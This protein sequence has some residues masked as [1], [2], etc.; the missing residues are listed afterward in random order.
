MCVRLARNLFKTS[1]F[2]PCRRV[3]LAVSGGSDSLALMFLVK[4]YLE[5]LLIPPEIIAVTVDHQLRKESAREAEIV[6]EICRDHHIKH[7]TVRWEGK[8]PKTHLA[9][10]ARIARYDLLVQ[11]AQKQGASLIMTGHTLNDQVETYQM[12][13]QRLQKRRGALRDEVGA[14]CDGGAASGFAGA[15]RDK[16]GARRDEDYVR[17]TRKNIAEKS[18][19]VLYERGL[20]CIPRE[21]LLHRKVRLIR[22]L[23]GVQRQ[24]LRNYLRL[25]GK[26]WID[27]P[28]NE[29]R[30]FERVRVRQSLSSQKLV[31][32]AQKINKAAWQRRQQAQNIADL[33]LALDITVQYGRCFIVKPAP[34]LQ[35][36]SC[37]PFV[38]GLFA[39][40]MGGGFYLLSNQKLSMLV[41]KLCLNSPEKRRFTCAGCVIEYNKEGI[42]LW[43]ERRN[44]KEALVEPDETL[45]W[46]GRYRITNHGSEAIK[47][48]VANLEQLKSLLQNS[49]SNLE[50][51]HFPSLQSLLMLSNDKG[52]D[53]PELISQAIIHKNVI[54]KRIMAPF[55]W[56]SS[57]EDAALVNVV[58]PFFNLEVKR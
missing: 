56:L 36:H 30:N 24:T 31:N 46:D 44:M 3:I 45:L 6:A 13:C 42:A 52:C 35:K 4:E 47:V 54:I 21:A 26:T 39:V 27:D 10:S 5:T 41:Q 12:R 1:D 40:L 2:I 16:A 20:S 33:I 29:D 8:K 18:Y 28:T 37:F 55:D 51:P 9:F 17:E 58:E 48:G 19:G 14:M 34:F 49:N 15:L 22:P 23:L 57:R 53:I 32:I 25:Q 7:I 50:K 38:V 43:R 11:E